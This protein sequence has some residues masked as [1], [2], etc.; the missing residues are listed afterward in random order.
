MSG[1]APSDNVSRLRALAVKL[2]NNVPPGF[3]S[4]DAST[5]THAA[6]ELEQRRAEVS[7][8]ELCQANAPAPIPML[9]WC[10]EC[11]DR[12]IDLDEF[13]IKAHHTHACQSCGMV[14]RPCVLPTC[15]VQWLPGFK[16]D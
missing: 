7:H 1:Q 8:L 10:P 11:G 16:N 15:G 9:L 13:A 4:P 12:H 5:C 6:D 2:D 3:I 14:W